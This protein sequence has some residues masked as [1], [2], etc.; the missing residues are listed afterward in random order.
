MTREHRRFY[1]ITAISIVL[2]LAALANANGLYR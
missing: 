2:L 1:L